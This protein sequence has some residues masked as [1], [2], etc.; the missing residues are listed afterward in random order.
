[1]LLE[2]LT[3][4]IEQLKYQSLC[5]RDWGITIDNFIVPPLIQL[6]MSPEAPSQVMQLGATIVSIDVSKYKELVEQ[7]TGDN[8]N[9]ENI[10]KFL[11]YLIEKVD[12]HHLVAHQTILIQVNASEYIRLDSLD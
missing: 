2:L 7:L 3:K 6:A 4:L 10:E 1:M 5:N 12:L 11:R 9:V 8:V